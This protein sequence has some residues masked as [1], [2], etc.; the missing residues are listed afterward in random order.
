MK[1]KDNSVEV[2]ICLWVTATAIV[3]SIL[4]FDTGWRLFNW[5]V[6]FLFFVMAVRYTWLEYYYRKMWKETWD[7]RLERMLNDER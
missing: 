2:A 6:G 4:E 3:L 5:F 7:R 1:Y